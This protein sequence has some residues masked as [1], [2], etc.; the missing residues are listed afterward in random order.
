MVIDVK[1]TNQVAAPMAQTITMT[2]SSTPEA[3]PQPHHLS[4]DLVHRLLV[5]TS[6]ASLLMLAFGV[7][8]SG[9]SSAASASTPSAQTGITWLGF[10]S[11]RLGRLF[12]QF[13][14]FGINTHK[15]SVF[16]FLETLDYEILYENTHMVRFFFYKTF[17]NSDIYVPINLRIFSTNNY[18]KKILYETQH[19]TYI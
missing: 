4:C 5:D 15:N 17:F 12:G 14:G 11:S 9:H 8:A 3:M 7:G 2:R 13:N 19:N 6:L 16:A 18:S 1:P 10:R